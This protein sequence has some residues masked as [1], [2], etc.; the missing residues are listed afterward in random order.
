MGRPTS[1][2]SRHASGQ[3][4]LAAGATQRR[5][6]VARGRHRTSANSR[7]RQLHA[8]R[9]SYP[10]LGSSW[11]R[12]RSRGCLVPKRA[13]C[14]PPSSARWSGSPER[15]S[16]IA[17]AS[18]SRSGRAAPPS[19]NQTAPAGTRWS[20]ERSRRCRRGPARIL[21]LP[22]R[23]KASS[24]ASHVVVVIVAASLVAAYV[25]RDESDVQA[26]ASAA[27]ES[28]CGAAE[29]GAGPRR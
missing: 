11:A 8:A 9:S 22:A 16:S 10:I 4:R 15:C 29:C 20:C 27:Q 6:R 7:P 28:C 3:R 13:P 17:I 2:S 26:N 24:S 14:S 25:S 1:S 21:L 5:N 18:S 12:T 23:T 19:F